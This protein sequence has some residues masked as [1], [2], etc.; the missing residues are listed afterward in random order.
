MSDHL[1]FIGILTII[2]IL[3]KLF[4]AGLGAKLAGYGYNS[5][6][7]VGAGMVS[8]GEMALI[9]AQTGYQIH[10]IDP[11]IYSSVIIIIVTTTILAPFIMNHAVKKA[12]ISY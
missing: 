2:A 12:I 4:G 10:L 3:T 1:L 6:Y 9:M 8:R 11:S 7:F 5:A